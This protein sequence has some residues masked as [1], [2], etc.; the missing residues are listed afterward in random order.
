MDMAKHII[1]ESGQPV[2]IESVAFAYREEPPSKSPSSSGTDMLGTPEPRRPEYIH[3]MK[4]T[5]VARPIP[6]T[7]TDYQK[8]C[9][10]VKEE[11]AKEGRLPEEISK[12][13]MM[14]RIL[15]E[16]LRARMR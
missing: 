3:Y 12:L 13:T 1:L 8:I 5:G 9:T 11:N 2:N 4:V 6:I 14:I 16:L 10:A 7:E 15:Y